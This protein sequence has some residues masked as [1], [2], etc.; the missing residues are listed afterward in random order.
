MELFETIIALLLAAALL[1]TLANRLAVPYPAL[2]ALAGA[3]AAFIPGVPTVTPDPAL[4][5]TLF[6]APVLLD[7]AFDAS[8]RDLKANLLPVATLALVAVGLTVASVAAVARWCLPEMPL[9]AA[10][11]LGAIVAPPDASAATAVLRRLRPPHRLLVVL[12][13]ES[14]FNDASALLIYRLALGAVVTGSFSLLG[15]GPTLLLTVGGGAL[16]GWAVARLYLALAER[17]FP[18]IAINVLVQ[19]LGTFG[20]WIAAEALH[21]SAII[22]VVVYGMTIARHAPRRMGARRRIVSYAV[23][24]VAVFVLNALAFLLIGLQMRAIVGRLQADW[25]AVA[26]LAAGTCV[27]VILTRIAWVMAYN[28]VIRWV[29]GRFG[30]SMPRPTWGDGLVAAW[31]GMRGVVTLATALALPEDLPHRDE[32]V[33]AAVCVVIVTLGLQGTTLGPLLRRVGLSDDGTVEAEAALARAETTKAAMRVL[34]GEPPSP[35]L[36][37]L[38]RELTARAE[39][40]EDGPPEEAEGTARLRQR[41]VDVSRDVLEELRRA[42]T[43]GDDA[44]HRIEEEL[45]LLELTADPR[46]RPA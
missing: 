30:L 11:A 44:F 4:V 23:W 22:T 26:L 3:V 12:E 29:I 45:D 2:L 5:L 20:V 27:A 6:V 17:L 25:G 38:R 19:F 40:G 32:I 7:A 8:P 41:A 24:E 1:T 42:G 33:F 28:T 21:L 18:D 10:V 14:L 37:T 9:A 43:I 35:A 16:F 36:E 46:V 13:G 34:E 39:L 15:A 31:C